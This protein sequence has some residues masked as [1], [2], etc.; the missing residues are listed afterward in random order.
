MPWF[1][2]DDSFDTH[3]KVIAA[4]NEATGLFVRCGTYCA[5]HLTD[6]FIPE[7]VALLYGSPELAESLVR[8]KLWRRVRGGWRMPDYLEYNPSHQQVDTERAAKTERQRRWRQNNSGRKSGNI[9]QKPV[10]NSWFDPQAQ[11]NSTSGSRGRRPVDAST[12]ASRDASRGAAPTPSP[13]RPEGS[14][15]GTAPKNSGRGRASPPGSPPPEKPPWCGLCDERSRQTGDPPAR[16]PNCHPLASPNGHVS[17]G[18]HARL[19]TT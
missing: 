1:R 17:K 5:R 4:G 19:E 7:H 8:A 10:D 15:A 3:P 14:G 13:P 6:G 16:C 2:L 11:R 9:D 18:R 12:E